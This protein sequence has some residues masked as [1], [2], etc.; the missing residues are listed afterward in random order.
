[1]SQAG[2]LRMSS[3]TLPPSVPT[4]FVTNSGTAVPIANIL[5]VLG[6]TVAAG[7]IPFQFTGSG[8]TVTGQLQFSQ[9]IAS[10]NATNVGLSA[11]NSSQFTVD[12]N[13]FVSLLSS[14]GGITTVG[15]VTSGTVAFNGTA[16]TTLTST[17]AGLTLTAANN[18]ASTGAA[19]NITGGATT[20]L[21]STGGQINIISGAGNGS[22]AAGFVFINPGAAG[23]TG[24]G[25]STVIVGGTGGVTSGN[26]GAISLGGGNA[27]TSGTGGAFSLSGGI[28][29]GTNI[30]AGTSS[31]T[32]ANGTGTGQVGK[33][34]VSCD[35]A[36]GVSGTTNHTT[37]LRFIVNGSVQTLTSGSASTIVTTG[38][39]SNS[40]AGGQILYTVECT[41]GTDYQC[42]SGMMAYAFV[43]KAGTITGTASLIGS[44]V[45]IASSGTLTNAFTATAAGLVRITPTSSLTPTLLRVTYSIFANDQHSISIP[46]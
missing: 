22:G 29:A 17:T 13:G 21:N 4:S 46:L 12:A 36:G 19:I 40:Y 26:G 7:T 24:N 45:T 42:T 3:S 1:M 38:I 30:N 34:A 37:V 27:T 23:V 35:A 33:F 16:G 41:N 28:G 43:N 15:D 25:A 8:N 6:S 44:E 31:L 11:F 9:A 18:S 39:P 5:N 32:T 2:L 10:T 20:H 14:G